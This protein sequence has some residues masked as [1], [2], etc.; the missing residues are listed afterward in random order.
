[1]VVMEE[2]LE[3]ELQLGANGWLITLEKGWRWLQEIVRDMSLRLQAEL[4]VEEGAI[5]LAGWLKDKSE[6]MLEII[7]ELEEG[8]DPRLDVCINWRRADGIMSVCKTLFNGGCD[9]CALLEDRLEGDIDGEEAHVA[10]E[11]ERIWLQKIVRDMSLRLQME[12]KVEG[13]AISLAGWL[14]EKS[15]DMLGIIWELEEGPDPRVDVCIDWRRANGI[16]SVCKTLF[17]EGRDLYALLEDRLEG[18]IDREDAD[19]P[20]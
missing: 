11:N 1:M 2:L 5:P 10:T 7:W 14:K 15:E 13:G 20:I 12:P 4:E 18:V 6:D 19:M 3:R 17:N 8:P 16:M 9:L